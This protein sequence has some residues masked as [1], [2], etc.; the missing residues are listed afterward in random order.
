MEDEEVAKDTG[1]EMKTSE[2]NS[3]VSEKPEGCSGWNAAEQRC[4]QGLGAYIR[5]GNME[6]SSDLRRSLCME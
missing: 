2:K 5:H 3:L 6:D 4:Q 1:E